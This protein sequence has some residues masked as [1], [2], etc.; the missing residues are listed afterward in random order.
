[1][2]FVLPHLLKLLAR[3]EWTYMQPFNEKIHQIAG[4]DS[5]LEDI[6]TTKHI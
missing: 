5:A 2:N 6:H 4:E 3:T 1:M